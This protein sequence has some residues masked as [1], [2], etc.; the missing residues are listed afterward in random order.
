M[1]N[2][3]PALRSFE[4]HRLTSANPTGGNAD[5]WEIGPGKTRALA[6]IE[7]ESMKVLSRTGGITEIQTEGRWS[8][9]KQLWW[10]DAKVG[11]TLELALPVA[12]SGRYRVVVNNTLAADYGIF[13]F[14]LDGEALGKPADFYSATNVTKRMTLGERDLAKGQHRLTVEVAGANAAAKPRHMFGLDYVKLEAV[15]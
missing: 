9:S 13:R 15:R 4:S 2:D 10:R 5:W 8:G 3:L 7:G 11:D 6:A 1:L 14:L 12:K